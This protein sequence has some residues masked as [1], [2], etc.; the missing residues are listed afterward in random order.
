MEIAGPLRLGGL[1]CRR[2]G[3]QSILWHIVGVPK[4][5]PPRFWECTECGVGEVVSK[6]PMK[7]GE[8]LP[9]FD[10]HTRIQRY[11]AYRKSAGLVP[12]GEFAEKKL[13]IEK[14]ENL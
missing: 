9:D 13:S 1:E 10:R 4:G 6:T 8:A 7:F 5:E 3:G 2:C 14:Y 11:E 12:L